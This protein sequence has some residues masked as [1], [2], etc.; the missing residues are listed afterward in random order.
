MI[1]LDWRGEDV[2]FIDIVDN[3]FPGLINFHSHPLLARIT[4]ILEVGPCEAQLK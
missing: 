1:N 4:D 2:A 3:F